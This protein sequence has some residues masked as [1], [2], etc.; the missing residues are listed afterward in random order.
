MNISN[1]MLSFCIFLLI[2]PF[3]IATDGYFQYYL[4]DVYQFEV[5][6]NSGTCGLGLS[7]SRTNVLSDVCDTEGS[8]KAT[9][10]YN[11]VTS[12]LSSVFYTINWDTNQSHCECAG[13]IYNTS[14]VF[15]SGL[16]NCCGDDGNETYVTA[17]IGNTKCC[18]LPNNCVDGTNTCRDEYLTNETSCDDGIDNDCD[19]IIDYWDNS[20][21]PT[22]NSNTFTVQLADGTNCFIVD[23]DGDVALKGN[24]TLGNISTIP[25][26]SFEINISGDVVA[27]IDQNCDLYIEGGVNIFQASILE[28]INN[29]L[30]QESSTGYVFKIDSS[31]NLYSTGQFGT[32]CNI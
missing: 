18:N 26:D 11:S 28:G 24:L 27:Y 15:D 16:G 13:H 21:C 10:Q 14:I 4:N 2:L 29:F 31:G 12:S 3:S 17:G 6:A 30:I 20:C 25:A 23:S 32:G 1:F 19:G 5:P 8:W 7:C 9:Y 22:I